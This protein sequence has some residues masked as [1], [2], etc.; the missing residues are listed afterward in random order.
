MYGGKFSGVIGLAL[1]GNS[2]VRPLSLHILVLC[3]ETDWSSRRLSIPARY[4]KR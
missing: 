2:L 4:L 1:P 3:P